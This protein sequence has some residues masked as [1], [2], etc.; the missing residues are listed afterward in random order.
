MELNDSM[1]EMS[2]EPQENELDGVVSEQSS[3]ESVT[4]KRVWYWVVA[5]LLVGGFIGWVFGRQSGL[6]QTQMGTVAAIDIQDASTATP[7]PTAEA[8]EPGVNTVSFGP[9]PATI[10]PEP[11]RTLGDASAPVTIVE[12]SDYQCPFCQRHFLETLPGLK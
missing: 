9:T 8:T 3:T 12:F 2:V 7:L 11:D 4:N 6:A 5:A 10:L 1:D